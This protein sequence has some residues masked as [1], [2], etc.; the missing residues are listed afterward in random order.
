VLA[1]TD[2]LVVVAG[3][4]GCTW[5]EFDRSESGQMLLEMSPRRIWIAHAAEPRDL[6]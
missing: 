6:G 5:K 3:D 1:D 4:V 2:G